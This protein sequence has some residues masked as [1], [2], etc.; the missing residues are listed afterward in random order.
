MQLFK[1]AWADP[2][3]R[4]RIL[5]VMLMFGVFALGI[6]IQVP[7]PG[8]RPEV[9]EELMKGNNFLGLLNSFGGGALKRVSIFSLGL[10][11]Y[12]TASI[13]LQVLTQANP[14]W[15]QELKEGAPAR[16][17]VTFQI[18]IEAGQLHKLAHAAR[19]F[20]KSVLVNG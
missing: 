8:L 4:Q 18:V 3:L 17:T 19:T 20:E 2:D 10:N 16:W 13:I 14:A 11:P 9:M 5:F 15:E 12:I 6:H 1:L 7:I